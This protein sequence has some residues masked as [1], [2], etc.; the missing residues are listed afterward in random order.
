MCA[1][2]YTKES[3]IYSI[4]WLF[5]QIIAFWKSSCRLYLNIRD[6]D[7]AD[8]HRLMLI[9]DQINRRMVVEN[10][11]ERVTCIELEDF[12]KT[13]CN[14]IPARAQRPLIELGPTYNY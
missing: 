12:L 14:T 10:I 7:H 5:S 11:T 2:A 13:K 3:D 8:Y 6:H 4:G 1:N 9:E